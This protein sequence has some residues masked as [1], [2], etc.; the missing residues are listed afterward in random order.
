MA[1]A[2]FLTPRRLTRRNVSLLPE[3]GGEGEAR[4]RIPASPGE[5]RVRAAGWGG[6][7]GLCTPIGLRGDLCPASGSHLAFLSLSFSFCK[8]GRMVTIPHR[9]VGRFTRHRYVKFL[10]LALAPRLVRVH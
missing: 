4:G 1:D 7:H 10:V 8:M 5:R 3:A 2:K 9:A 6:S